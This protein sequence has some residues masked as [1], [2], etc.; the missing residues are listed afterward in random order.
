[1]SNI[2]SENVRFRYEAQSSDGMTFSGFMEAPSPEDAR[3]RLSEMGLI[4]A[5]L[6]RAPQSPAPTV[7]ASL[8][9]AELASLNQQIV[10][11]TETGMPLEK[12]LRLIA[13]DLPNRKLAK[14]ITAIADRLE[15]GD[16]IK[17]AIDAQGTRFPGVY[18]RLLEIGVTTGNPHGV[19]AN[20]NKQL[21]LTS[22]LRSTLWNTLT[23]PVFVLTALIVMLYYYSAVLVPGMMAIY[24]DFDAPLPKLTVLVINIADYALPLLVIFVVLVV[25]AQSLWFI[26]KLR[27]NEGGFLQAFICP[28]PLIGRIIKRS[29]IAQWCSTMRLA[30]TSGIDLPQAVSLA[31]S[32]ALLPVLTKDSDAVEKVIRAGQSLS[33]TPSAKELPLSLLVSLELAAQ[34]GNL[35]ET[36]ESLG[37]LYHQQAENR[38]AVLRATLTP[39]AMIVVAAFAGILVMAIFLPIPALIQSITSF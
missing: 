33:T 19:L 26:A 32:G 12:G 27:R 37:S 39:V 9:S 29:A 23:Y 31:G 5:D 13:N 38:L 35:P 20:L 1:M 7:G 4:V 16:T 11:I 30:V 6:H 17:Q 25:T 10:Q 2:A 24:E 3:H 18:G 34:R 28:I 15:A 22:R 21:D 14:T 36:L 8:S